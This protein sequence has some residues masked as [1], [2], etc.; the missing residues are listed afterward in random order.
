MG[1]NSTR[2]TFKEKSKKYHVF[3]EGAIAFSAINFEISGSLNEC[4][5]EIIHEFINLPEDFDFARKYVGGYTNDYTNE[6][7]Q[8]KILK[9]YNFGPY[10]IDILELQDYKEMSI[11]DF[12]KV[13]M[14]MLS[15]YNNM[16]KQEIEYY[17]FIGKV[18][19]DF[20]E[21]KE[22]S[23]EFYQVAR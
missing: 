8:R 4:G 11:D 1:N 12:K 17:Q 9:I 5:K 15:E 16:P 21:V 23:N 20:D 10:P 19:S 13:A 3:G 6:F 2:M 18:K 7:G 14:E 22:N